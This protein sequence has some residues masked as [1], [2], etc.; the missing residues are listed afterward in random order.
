M[1]VEKPAAQTL[2]KNTANILNWPLPIIPLKVQI[3][4]RKYWLDK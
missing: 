4:L 2:Y 1:S 3:S